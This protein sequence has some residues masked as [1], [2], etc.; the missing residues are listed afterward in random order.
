MDR[1]RPQ[2]T[3]LALAREALTD[4]GCSVDLRRP[5]TVTVEST[6][7]MPGARAHALRSRLPDGPYAIVVVDEKAFDEWA[8]AVEPELDSWLMAQRA[9]VQRG[10]ASAALRFFLRRQAE[11][12]ADPGAWGRDLR[13]QMSAL[14]ALDEHDLCRTIDPSSV[15]RLE[16]ERPARLL[17]IDA[18]THEVPLV[19]GLGGFNRCPAPEDHAVVFRHLEEMY[20]CKPIGVARDTVIFSV[21]RP[22]KTLT[23][24]RRAAWTRFLYGD[25]SLYSGPRGLCELALESR[26]SRWLCWWD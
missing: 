1:E 7:V 20:G 2:R 6:P 22:P 5:Q 14:E 18:E 13:A 25:P 8:D 10:G 15:S 21:A 19:L 12:L 26:G 24:L 17:L 23:A 4:L 9:A 11:R 3:K 16:I